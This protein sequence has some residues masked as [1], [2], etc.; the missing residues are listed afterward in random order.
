MLKTIILIGGP[1]KGTRFRPLSLDIP[2]P[3]FPV[4]G[5]PMI[6]HHIEAASKVPDMKEIIIIGSY[7]PNDQLSRFLNTM[8]QDFKIL[9]RY[10]QEYTALGTGGGMYH[11]RDQINSG[12]PNL[13]FVLNADVCCDFPL[14]E[15]IDFQRESSAEFVILGTEVATRQQSL[16][17][18][19]I[20]ED[21]TSHQVKHYVEKPETFV[22]TTINCGIYLFTPEIFS[23]IGEAFNKNQ[24]S[25]SFDLDNSTSQMPQEVIRLEQDIFAQQLAGSGKLYVYHTTKFWSQIK[26]AGAAIYA[27]RHYLNIYRRTHPERLAKSSPEG[28]IV[29]DNVFIHPTASVHPSATLGPN[30]TIGKGVTIGAG[31]RIRES[32]VLEGSIV[33]DHSCIL[34]TIVGWNSMVGQWTRVEGTPNDPN[35]NKPFAKLDITDLFNTD[36]RLNPS[37]TVIGS[38]VQIPSEVIVLNSIVLPHKEL[39]RS[40]KNQ[41]IL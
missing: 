5:F 24:E 27:N 23:Y 32:M 33:Q 34:Y 39:N 16:N 13:L 31:V 8:Q 28:P 36:G 35:P 7:Q 14:Q 9:I 10:L 2:K 3:L 12:N 29:I 15:M 37:I 25:M 17:Y 4:A 19:C 41:I 11:F 38:N 22:S 21:K 26:S 20:A 1:S 40:Y 30:V 18:G 6:H